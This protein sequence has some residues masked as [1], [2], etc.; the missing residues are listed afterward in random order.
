MKQIDINK[1]ADLIALKE[2]LNNV[3]DKKI[4]SQR[5]SEKLNEMKNLSFGEYKSLYDDIIDKLSGINISE[6]MKSLASYVKLLKE[7]KA[8][9][10]VYKIIDR[11]GLDTSSDPTI[12]AYAWATILESVDKKQLKEGEKKMYDIYKNACNLVDGITPERI[13]TVLAE[14]K[15]INDAVKYLTRNSNSSNINKLNERVSSINALSNLVKESKTIEKPKIDNEKPND[16]LISELNEI[17][18]NEYKDWENK[19]LRDLSICYASGSDTK[20]L[21]ENYKTSCIEAIDSVNDDDLTTKSRLHGMKQQLMEKEYNQ[22]TIQEDLFKL[23][24]LKETIL[25]G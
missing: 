7:N 8:I 19:V 20:E 5:L 14:S 23:A 10:S 6:S 3:I 9:R 2:S 1:S 24:E 17:F 4:A 11:V 21:F 15:T 22:E 16:D 25:N 13:D 12:T 18:V